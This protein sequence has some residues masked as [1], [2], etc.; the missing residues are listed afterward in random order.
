[1]Q[2]EGKLMR[3]LWFNTFA[4]AL[5]ILSGCTEKK[6]QDQSLVRLQF[7]NPLFTAP[8]AAKVQSSST[9]TGPVNGDQGPNW[10]LSDPQDLSQINCWGIFVGGPEEKLSRQTCDNPN[11]DE[12]A[13]FGLRAG[14]FPIGSNGEL[15]V[16]A[17]ERRRFYLVGLSSANGQC[18]GGFRETPDFDFRNYS[19]PFIIGFAE[20]DLFG[21]EVEVP[22]LLKNEFSQ[23]NKLGDCDFFPIQEDD[24]TGVL[25][26]LNF[27]VSYPDPKRSTFV[28]DEV[29]LRTVTFTHTGVSAQCSRDGGSTFGSC[30]TPT[31]LVWNAADMS[32]THV[33]RVVDTNGNVYEE[34]FRPDLRYPGLDIVTC[35]HEVTANTNFDESMIAATLSTVDGVLC[36]ADGVTVGPGSTT[37]L[38]VSQDGVRLIARYGD[39]A[40][41]DQTGPDPLINI[42]SRTNI[43]VVGLDLQSSA[44]SSNAID[45]INSNDV[46]LENLNVNL[47]G[48]G[49]AV[50]MNMSGATTPIHIIGSYLETSMGETL[51]H[52]TSSVA[53]I[54]DSLIS[55]ISG[56]ATVFVGHNSM[57]TIQQS[58][59][60]NSSTLATGHL[61]RVFR[62]GTLNLND[63][64]ILDGSGRGV[65]S[66]GQDGPPIDSPTL[67]LDQN[68]FVRLIDNDSVEQAAIRLEYNT[69]TVNAQENLTSTLNGNF[70]CAEDA[71]TVNYTAMT[72]GTLGIGSNWSD[73]NQLNPNPTVIPNCPQDILDLITDL[74]F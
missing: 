8:S 58:I 38:T 40:T 2:W 14:F 48:T 66:Q 31:S 28:S 35:S 22:I 70:F 57:A 19:A 39:V 56:N 53:V 43:R 44:T 3:F 30:T 1:L 59:L 65:V 20:Q 49:S 60:H 6:E 25:P 47:N 74:G 62:T 24:P 34:S 51:H 73:A 21:A 4:I 13:S 42:N 71:G 41:L 27:Q 50:N 23:A 67:N 26:S 64:I 36:F 29:S 7:N 45:I 72:S 69:A 12:I 52:N 68:T 9:T 18:F 37:S 46:R 33:I 15:F 10:G 63:S 16:P 32:N 61:A 55:S 17:G 5:L 11:D 54:V